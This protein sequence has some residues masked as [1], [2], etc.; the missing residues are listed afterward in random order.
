MGITMTISTLLGS[1]SS[2]RLLDVTKK[3][4]IIMLVNSTALLI[5][6]MLFAANV[7]RGAVWLDHLL[8]VL[9]GTF[10]RSASNM[11]FQYGIELSYPHS[12]PIMAGLTSF[13]QQILALVITQIG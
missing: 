12:V 4:K 13:A 2:A 8:L 7:D 10:G 6:L 1:L 9:M 5:F 11:T 3:Y